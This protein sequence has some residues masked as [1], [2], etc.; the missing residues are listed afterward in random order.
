LQQW[1]RSQGSRIGQHSRNSEV[2]MDGR[3]GQGGNGVECYNVDEAK[4][5]CVA[6]SVAMAVWMVAMETCK[7]GGIGGGLF[8]PPHP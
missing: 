2:S 4:A 3:V 8:Q 1:L 6:V 7:R 5:S